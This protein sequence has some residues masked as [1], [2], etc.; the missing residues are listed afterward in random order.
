MN[1]QKLVSIVTPCFNGEDY[2]DRYFSCILAQTYPAIELIF[3]DD[4]SSDRTLQIA[5]SWRD[6]LEGRG[7]SYKLLTHANGGQASAINMGLREVTG[8]YITWP[9]SDDILRAD[10]IESKAA[11]LDENPGLGLVVSDVNIADESDPYRVLGRQHFDEALGPRIFDALVREKSG[12]FCSGIAYMARTQCLFEAIG[13]RH[14]Y[15]SRSGQ[16]WQLLFPLTYHYDAG[17]INEPLATYIV[18]KDSHSHSYISLEQQLRRTYELQDIID[19]VLPGMHMSKDDHAVY[20]HS[21]SIKYLS[22]RFKLAIGLGNP[23][24]AVLTSSALDG[25]YGPSWTRRAL[26]QACRMGFG[27]VVY[28]AARAVKAAGRRA[29]GII[30]KE[31]RNA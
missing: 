27:P 31:G 22:Q 24:L 28:K 29:E 19:H 7:I 13:G 4:G 12:S 6:R 15:E 16:N 5:E 8:E 30:W 23:E 3:I 17:F 10:A 21:V 11:F 20:T 25:E 14:I 9:D 26:L 1:A 18:R 2:L